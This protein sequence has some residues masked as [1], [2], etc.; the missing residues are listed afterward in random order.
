[1]ERIIKMKNNK[2]MAW[3]KVTA[4][5]TAALTYGFWALDLFPELTLGPVGYIDDAIVF[6]LAAYAVRGAWFTI[7]DHKG[8]LLKKNWGPSKKR[9]KKR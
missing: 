3:I 1:M 5:G 2:Y 7:M 4:F 9:S 8:D 6:F